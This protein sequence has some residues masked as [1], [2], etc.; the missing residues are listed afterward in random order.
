VTQLGAITTLPSTKHAVAYARLAETLGFS[1][2]GLADTA[3]RLY[4]AVYPAVTACLL[5]TERVSV[6]TFV[7]NPV[8]RHWSVHAGTAQGL[9]ELAP[10]RFF[11][12]LA[13]GDGAVHS[14]GLKPAKLQYFEQ[15]VQDMRPLLPA[16]ANVHMVFSG[17]KGVEVAG[18]LASE[19]TIG[20]GLDAGALRELARRA[21]VARAAAGVTEPLRIWAMASTHLASS[22]AELARLRKHV[23]ALAIGSARFAFDFSFDGKNVPEEFQPILRER[24]ARYDFAYHAKAGDHPNA[25]LFDDRPDIENYL[26]D[27]MQLVGTPEQCAQRLSDLV[28]DAEVD[29]V[30]IPIIPAPGAPPS[31]QLGRLVQAAETFGH[32]AT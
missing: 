20:V 29:G 21:R 18:R 17:T 28:R 23:R 26:V 30:W 24:L 13:T 32:L 6:G 5:G 2:V 25:H 8:T 15:Y 27:R 11:M 3:P 14:V 31:A 19:L 1:R 12:G 22:E 16:N 9:E 10:G 7:T 4:H